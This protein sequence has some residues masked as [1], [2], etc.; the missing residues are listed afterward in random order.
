MAQWVKCLLLKHGE[1]RPGPQHPHEN[2]GG[3]ARETDRKT[4]SQKT[5][6]RVVDI[7]Q[8]MKSLGTK[9]DHLSS[10]PKTPR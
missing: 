8:W 3:G 4:L 1:P 6:V 7:V 2:W 5:R 10:S 9:P